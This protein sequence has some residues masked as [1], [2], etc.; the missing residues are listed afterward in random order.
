MI[1]YMNQTTIDVALNPRK[2]KDNKWMKSAKTTAKIKR[3]FNPR[4][5][6]TKTYIHTYTYTH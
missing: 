2:E 1:Y 4:V 5:G 3:I 6:Q